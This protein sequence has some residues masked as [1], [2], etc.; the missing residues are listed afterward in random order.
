MNGV[1]CLANCGASASDLMLRNAARLAEHW[2]LRRDGHGARARWL[3]K[4]PQ[5]E[6]RTRVST[7][8]CSAGRCSSICAGLGASVLAWLGASGGGGWVGGWS[9][10]RSS[11]WPWSSWWQWWWWWWW[12]W[13]GGGKGGKRVGFAAEKRAREVGCWFASSFAFLAALSLHGKQIHSFV[14]RPRCSL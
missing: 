10:S 14:L 5:P 13:W 2:I 7:P 1:S 3:L 12:W 11:W 4:Q 9:W 8:S 6:G